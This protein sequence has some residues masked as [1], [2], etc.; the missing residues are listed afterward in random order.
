MTLLGSEEA[1]FGHVRA[2]PR[3]I[4]LLLLLLLLLLLSSCS[5]RA[6]APAPA[7]AP[8]PASAPVPTLSPTVV[9]T[10]PVCGRRP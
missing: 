1:D 8:A 9:C 3:A 4:R 10:F 6:P 5:A 2:K 7:L